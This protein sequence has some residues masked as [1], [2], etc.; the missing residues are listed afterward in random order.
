MTTIRHK[1][2][3]DAFL[4]RIIK[5]FN[6]VFVALILTTYAF[7]SHAQKKK[8]NVVELSE[9]T[10]TGR[11]QKPV[12]AVDISRIAPKLSL[13][14]LKQPF[15]ERIEQV[16]LRDP[17][18]DRLWRIQRCMVAKFVVL[19]GF[20][21]YF[22]FFR[23]C[24]LWK[25]FPFDMPLLCMYLRS[26][27]NECSEFFLR[28]VFLVMLGR[29]HSL[30]SLAAALMSCDRCQRVAY[31]NEALHEIQA[32]LIWSQTVPT[33]MMRAYAACLTLF[34]AVSLFR[35]QGL[36][37]EI[38]YMAVIGMVFLGMMNWIRRD[39]CKLAAM[40]GQALD[41]WVHVRMLSTS[42]GSVEV[43]PQ[44]NLPLMVDP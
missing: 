26:S 19:S 44:K 42:K 37:A 7:A 9:I 16:I 5:Q 33:T 10:I 36:S 18:L 17:F 8:S 41:S 38:I 21:L 32:E 25:G 30:V 27:T 35:R 40:T 1:L 2:Q 29:N 6:Y 3:G 34:L 39:T 12:A 11:V 31:C 23:I 28:K 43:A 14:E 15:L 22:S 4:W 20:F 13:A 24:R